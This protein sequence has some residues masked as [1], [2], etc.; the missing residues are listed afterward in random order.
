MTL[1]RRSGP[2]ASRDNSRRPTTVFSSRLPT[3]C[4]SARV[5]LALALRLFDE[6][7][8][9][10]FRAVE[11]APDQFGRDLVGSRDL[12]RGVD[13]EA[14]AT[15]RIGEVYLRQ[16]PKRPP[17][18]M[19]HG[20]GLVEHLDQGLYLTVPVAMQRP[21]EQR[22]LAA[23]GVVQAAFPDAERLDEALWVVAAYPC[24]QNTCIACSTAASSSNCLGLPM[25]TT[26][27]SIFR[28]G[29]TV[30]LGLTG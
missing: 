12:R 3:A 7:A 24:R 27:A 13:G 6:G 8:E 5:D 4:A 18:P 22:M 23:D 10:L 19:L 11:H 28:N 14:A 20:P 9:G 29:R 21:L 25:G 30:I 17:Q 1:E 26:L 15:I 2:S 16:E